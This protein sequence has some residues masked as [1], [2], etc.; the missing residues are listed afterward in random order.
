MGTGLD[1]RGHRDER[2]YC[3]ATAARI[4]NIGCRSRHIDFDFD[5]LRGW[6]AAFTVGPDFGSVYS[7]RVVLDRRYRLDRRYPSEP[8]LRDHCGLLRTRASQSRATG[9][10]LPGPCHFAHAAPVPPP[11]SLVGGNIR[12]RGPSHLR[13]SVPERGPAFGAMG[14]GGEATQAAIP[15]GP[16]TNSFGGA[17]VPGWL[18]CGKARFLTI[19]A[20]WSPLDVNHADRRVSSGPRPGCEARVLSTTSRSVGWAWLG[21][22]TTVTA[23][24]DGCSCSS[25]SE[26]RNCLPECVMH[27]P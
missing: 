9:A 12:S 3:P 2:S 8:E 6:V 13:T 22:A 15:G 5:F 10:R 23:A 25:S 19:P 18:S 4:G 24:G 26:A 17:C 21:A 16:R 1:L 14:V 27:Q 20:P 11:L 7:G